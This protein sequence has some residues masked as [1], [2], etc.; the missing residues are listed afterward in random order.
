MWPVSLSLSLFSLHQSIAFQQQL[1]QC[2]YKNAFSFVYLFSLLLLLLL[3]LFLHLLA[4]TVFRTIYCSCLYPI[5][6]SVYGNL[7]LFVGRRPPSGRPSTET[8]AAAAV[9]GRVELFRP[10]TLGPRTYA[11][12]YA[13][14]SRG[15]ELLTRTFITLS[16]YFLRFT[17]I[18]RVD[19]KRRIS[20]KDSLKRF[21]L[22]FF[23]LFPSVGP[24]LVRLWSTVRS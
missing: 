4:P 24:S 8:R 17:S 22:L 9:A 11:D 3:L 19:C 14:P 10:R 5:L 6:F 13:N 20:V 2:V 12:S 7:S 15:R 1:V 21:D 23:F 16:F 18:R